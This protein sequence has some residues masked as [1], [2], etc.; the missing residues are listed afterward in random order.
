VRART[1]FAAAVL[2]GLALAAS[3]AWALRL[4]PSGHP[5]ITF[6]VA[7]DRESLPPDVARVMAFAA[8]APDYFEFDN[9]AAHSQPDNPP[10]TADGRIAVTPEQWRQAQLQA[11]AR[12]D[13][14]HRFYLDA[15]VDAMR[16][17]RRERAAVLLGY[18]LHN[19]QDL[20]THRGMT[21]WQH[22]AW[23]ANGQ[24]PDL[25]AD[26][27]QVARDFT[28]R[29]IEEFRRQIGDD[30]W[31]LF[32][33]ET[34]RRS[35]IGSVIPEPM[36]R[37]APGL[38]GWN[39]S[40]GVFPVPDEASAHAVAALFKAANLGQPFY[41]YDA[42]GRF[43]PTSAVHAHNAYAGFFLRQDVLVEMLDFP[44]RPPGFPP[45]P[46]PKSFDDLVDYA[47]DAKA[48]E[49]DE[50]EAFRALTPEDPRLLT[51]T[52]W[53]RL[54][55]DYFAQRQRTARAREVERLT[56]R[57]NELLRQQ[58]VNAAT[59]RE[60]ETEIQ[61]EARINAEWSDFNRTATL[62]PPTRMSHPPAASTGASS[63]SSR[64]AGP[65]AAREP[66]EPREPRGGR[67]RP[68][69]FYEPGIGRVCPVD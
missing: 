33:G 67:S 40:T 64:N 56:A 4:G 51:T 7:T 21:N 29:A 6:Q 63:S 11:I 52:S 66:R 61:S 42:S 26:R 36:T 22:A 48:F 49:T 35:G 43:A 69:C 38:A 39:P 24:S 60:V 58:T 17:G 50:A 12:A 8:G 9:L 68:E 31:R 2:A 65:A 41:T 20:A 19:R 34:L 54:L 47:E 5:H 57:K 27:I 44:G 16:H 28:R 30:N 14:W 15:A 59:R 10:L 13:E 32:R 25:Q 53:A 23:D 55:P 1:A 46:E 37:L 3:P 18:A 45:V 62:T